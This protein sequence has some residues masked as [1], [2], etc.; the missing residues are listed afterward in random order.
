[1][2]FPSPEVVHN[3]ANID[4][5]TPN[6]KG[7][8]FI[9]WLEEESLDGIPNYKRILEHYRITPDWHLNIVNTALYFY[10]KEG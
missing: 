5:I 10:N 4:L 2:I 3:V 8:D 1:M 7:I 6:T 9:K